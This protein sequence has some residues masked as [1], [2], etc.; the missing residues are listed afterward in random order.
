M[1]KRFNVN[2]NVGE[3]VLRSSIQNLENNVMRCEYRHTRHTAAV[4]A[5][6]LDPPKAL[7]GA[8]CGVEDA[9]RRR[10]CRSECLSLAAAELQHSSTEIWSRRRGSRRL[11]RHLWVHNDSGV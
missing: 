11:L 4:L 3:E 7:R 9:L 5:L 10:R 8:I 1:S 2:A 6:H